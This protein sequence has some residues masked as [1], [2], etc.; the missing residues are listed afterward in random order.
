MTGRPRRALRRAVEIPCELIT[1]YLDEPL[2]YWATDLSPHGLWL[3]TGFPM[4]IGEVVVI[5][6]EPAVWWKARPL[7][8][9]AEVVRTTRGGS[10]GMGLGFVDITDHEQRALRVWLRGRPP[11]LPRRRPRTRSGRELPVRKNLSI[12]TNI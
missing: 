7:V 8:L 9:F 3:D 5:G 6:F 11:P 1:R 2:V 12:V 10:A 4:E